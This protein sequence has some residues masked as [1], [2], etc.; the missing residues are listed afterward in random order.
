M[1][2]ACL[3]RGKT[4]LPNECLGYDTKQSDGEAPVLELWG[5]WSTSSL[6]FWLEVVAPDKCSRKN[7]VFLFGTWIN[8]TVRV[9]AYFHQMRMTY[10]IIPDY[11]S[12]QH[13][14]GE[15]PTN[16]LFLRIFWTGQTYLLS[17]PFIVA[18]S[19]HH[20][21]NHLIYGPL[22]STLFD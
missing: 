19:Q 8:L 14:N 6:P 22:E 11:F 13:Q 3:Q 21:E 12:G 16:Y 10:P 7:F 4:P 20:E 1:P 5:M 9:V 15:S 2:T 17:T 18:A